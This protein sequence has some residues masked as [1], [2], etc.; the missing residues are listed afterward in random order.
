MWLILVDAITKWP[1][2]IQMSSTSNEHTV[3]IL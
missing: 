1:E 3:G 2:V